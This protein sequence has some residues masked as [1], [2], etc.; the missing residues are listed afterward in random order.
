[1]SLSQC[2]LPRRPFAIEAVRGLEQ[3]NYAVGK[4]SDFIK[5]VRA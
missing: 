3:T 1:M 5:H 4:G 2:M